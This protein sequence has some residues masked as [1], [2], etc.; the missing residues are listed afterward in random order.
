MICFGTAGNWSIA[1]NPFFDLISIPPNTQVNL[2]MSFLMSGSILSAP[3]TWK[4]VYLGSGSTTGSQPS[5]GTIP[6]I[7]ANNGFTFGQ[8][9][10]GIIIDNLYTFGSNNILEFKT[11][12]SYVYQ[13]R[14]I[15]T[16]YRLSTQTAPTFVPPLNRS[17]PAWYLGNTI[18]TPQTNPYPTDR[19]R[20]VTTTNQYTYDVF[21]PDQ[22]LAPKAGDGGNFGF[23]GS[24]SSVNSIPAGNGGYYI[25][26]SF[27]YSNVTWVNTGDVK[28]NVSWPLDN[29]P[30]MPYDTQV[31]NQ[32]PNANRRDLE[33]L[34]CRY[35]CA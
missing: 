30:Q 28:G 22:N 17:N 15:N 13:E 34:R 35:S 8:I 16:L 32:R 26:N 21:F 6:T 25:Q 9:T 23:N 12:T 11:D 1:V 20:I 4:N 19:V 33:S 29:L 24:S 2:V 10:H 18:T 27:S 5:G 3:V 14:K 7:Q 31:I